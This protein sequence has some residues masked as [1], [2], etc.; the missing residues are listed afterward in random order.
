MAAEERFADT[1]E[2]NSDTFAMRNGANAPMYGNERG[3]LTHGAVKVYAEPESGRRWR[4]PFGELGVSADPFLVLI[5]RTGITGLKA[6][7]DWVHLVTNISWNLSFSR[8]KIF[9]KASVVA[10]RQNLA[11]PIESDSPGEE[12]PQRLRDIKRSCGVPVTPSQKATRQ[13]SG[14]KASSVLSG[15]HGRPLWG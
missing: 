2:L 13:P 4:W 12:P 11:D 7:F 1:A 14:T 15:S 10:P 8:M 5:L 3:S 6:T 9:E